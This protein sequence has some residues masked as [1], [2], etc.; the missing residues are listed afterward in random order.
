MRKTL[1]VI[2][3]IVVSATM[4]SGCRN[5]GDDFIIYEA[6]TKY[7]VT[8]DI[9]DRYKESFKTISSEYIYEDT[10][11]SFMVSVAVTPIEYG[12]TLEEY[13]AL[14][15]ELYTTGYITNGDEIYSL[16]YDIHSNFTVLNNSVENIN[17]IDMGKMDITYNL[18]QEGRDYFIK[19]E[20]YAVIN[21]DQIVAFT[22]LYEE[23][24]EEKFYEIID[25]IVNSIKV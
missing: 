15:D 10:K 9:P 1:K 5:L 22:F 3:L 6:V 25:H 13:L 24:D 20:M 2:L 11:S 7:G 19:E 4:V 17:G 12:P 14:L 16:T 23:K 18:E 21:D 8:F